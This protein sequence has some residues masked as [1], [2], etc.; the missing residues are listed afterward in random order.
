MGS[1][2]LIVKINVVWIIPSSINI[3]R[4]TLIIVIVR[5]F[6]KSRLITESACLHYKSLVTTYWLRRGNEAITARKLALA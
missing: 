5:N 2:E 3:S 6:L 1:N 4:F